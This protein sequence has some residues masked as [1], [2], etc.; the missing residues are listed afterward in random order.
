ML[1]IALSI[2]FQEKYSSVAIIFDT[3]RAR[4]F[5]T[6]SAYDMFVD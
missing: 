5:S 3:Q 4:S 2:I 1:S 6:I